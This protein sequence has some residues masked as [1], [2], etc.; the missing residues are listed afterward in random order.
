MALKVT[1]PGQNTG[2]DRVGTNDYRS[3][4]LGARGTDGRVFLAGTEAAA[5]TDGPL[6]R[7]IG[8]LGEDRLTS[9]LQTTSQVSE[10]TSATTGAAGADGP[11]VA[12]AHDTVVANSQRLVIAVTNGAVVAGT[13][14]VEGAAAGGDYLFT[15][16]TGTYTIHSG[17]PATL[18]D[19]TTY[20]IDV[21]YSFQL[22]DVDEKNFRGVNFKGSLDDTEGSGKAT[23]W[24]GFGEYETDQFVTS[25]AYAVGQE[26]RF[27]HSSHPMGAGLLTNQAGGATVVAII[28]GRVNKVPTASDPFLGFDLNISP[29]DVP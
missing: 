3:G 23:V 2:F 6:N 9:A 4:Q 13:A 28:V 18:I 21:T 29:S 11:A 5:A 16:A 24:K 27:T 1:T 15:D 20:E 19:S 7:P 26:L 14:L 8:I 17:G 25:V 22:D 10:R 12:L